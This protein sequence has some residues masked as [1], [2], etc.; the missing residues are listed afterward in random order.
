MSWPN[1]LS[2][3]TAQWS[4]APSSPRGGTMGTT[5]MVQPATQYASPLG[6]P[7]GMTTVVQPSSLSQVP[8][9]A[10]TLPSGNIFI[11]GPQGG[12]FTPQGME[13]AGDITQNVDAVFHEFKQ[14]SLPEQEQ[15]VQF[16]N[17]R[18]AK[19]RQ[20]KQEHMTW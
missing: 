10:Q 4:T 6:S 16:V 7:R 19:K 5:T 8:Q 3:P 13:L 15:F 17:E 11:P 2:L 14:L 9:G 12:Y 1:S 20:W 18:M